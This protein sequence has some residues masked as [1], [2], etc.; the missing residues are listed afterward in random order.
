MRSVVS[1]DEKIMYHHLTTFSTLGQ[2]IVLTSLW[3]L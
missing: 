3:V 1:Q 2:A